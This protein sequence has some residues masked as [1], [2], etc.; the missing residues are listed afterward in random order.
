MPRPW[1]ELKHAMPARAKARMQK[2]T[3]A[4]D[5]VVSLLELLREREVTQ[6]T[7]AERIGVA[8]GNISRTL[9]R[10]DPHL[11]TL[12]DVIAALGGELELVARFPDRDYAIRI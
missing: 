6:G 12:R 5:A 4:L 8:Q 7:L 10:S 3:K 9:R 1:K 2:R 11:S